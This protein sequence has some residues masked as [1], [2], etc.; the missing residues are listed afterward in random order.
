L[1]F[2]PNVE[3]HPARRWLAREMPVC[4]NTDDPG[5]FGISMTDEFYYAVCS[6]DLGLAD[7]QRLC[8]QSLNY[9]FL[10]SAEKSEA[11]NEFVPRLNEYVERYS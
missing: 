1:G 9:S 10:P 8:M 11:I 4:L 5:I 2:V 7:I 6:F 3:K